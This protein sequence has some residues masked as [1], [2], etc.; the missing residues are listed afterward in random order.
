MGR[1]SSYLRV[2]RRKWHLTQDELAFLLGYLNQPIIARLERGE[3]AVTV[4][5]AHTCELVFGV[6]PRELFPALFEG[7]EE[8]VLARLHE[9]HK[10]LTAEDASGRTL[11][12]LQLLEDAIGRLTALQEREI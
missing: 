10:R 1:L 9:L 3:R 2:H 5:V 11:A 4:A 6:E 12:K 7:V 8:R